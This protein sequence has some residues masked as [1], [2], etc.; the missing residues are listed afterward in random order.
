VV[1]YLR[2]GG[3]GL[4]C[5]EVAESCNAAGSKKKEKSVSPVIVASEV[6]VLPSPLQILNQPL[7]A[8][9]AGQSQAK[10]GRSLGKGAPGRATRLTS[11]GLAEN[12]PG[13]HQP[14]NCYRAYGL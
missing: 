5:G 2:K 4:S 6:Q 9:G 7:D 12:S 8:V 1:S 14:G 11:T 3:T 13:K 10:A